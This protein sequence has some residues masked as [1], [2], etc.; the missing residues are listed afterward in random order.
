L[1]PSPDWAERRKARIPAGRF[2]T[3]E[4]LAELAGY[5]LSDASDWMRGEVVAFD[6]GEWLAGA[7]E[8]ND[9]LDLTASDWERLRGEARR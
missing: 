1:L 2:G 4:E 8:F 6:G 7:G 9:L 5:L 3:P